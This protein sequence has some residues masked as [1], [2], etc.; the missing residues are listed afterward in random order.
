MRVGVVHAPAQAGWWQRQQEGT[1]LLRDQQRVQAALLRQGLKALVATTAENVRYLTD[2]D[3]PALFIYRYPGAYAVAL[4]DQEPMLIIPVSGLEYIIERPVTTGSVRTTGTYFVGRRSGASLSPAEER[5]QDLRATCPHYPSAEEGILVLLREAGAEAS[6]VGVDEQGI[7]PAL[8]RA[9]S[10]RLPAGKLVEAS[11]AFSEIRRI[12]TSDEISL[13]RQAAAINERAAARAFEVAR[14]GVAEKVLEETFWTE[15]AKGGAV[16]GH[17]ETTL[18]PRSSSSFHAGS[19]PGRQ[20]DLIRSDSSCRFRGYWSDIGRTRVVG[21]P[22][23]DH[24]KTYEALRIGQEAAL[25]AVRPGVRVGDLFALAVDTIRRSGLP[26]YRRHHVGHGIG[27]EMYEAPLLVEDSDARLEAG[28]V[29]NVETPY[30][31]SGYGGFQVEDT[32]LVTETGG[33][34]LT[35]ADRALASAG[36]A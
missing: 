14:V 27:L 11:A 23:P 9:L 4:P 32:V 5:L 20:G 16:P 24:V 19:Y 31:E 29:I 18:G 17:W 34:V 21:S 8:W 28:M 2:Y 15:I 22:K 10:E 26:E 25:E 36:G 3:T 6:A 7:P 1:Y 13:L 35:A 30:Y 33:E 12:K